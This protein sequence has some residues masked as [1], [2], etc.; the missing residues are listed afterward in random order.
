MRDDCGASGRGC[1]HRN[2]F[3]GVGSW[4]GN[5]APT[6]VRRS[7]APVGDERRREFAC[8]GLS[9]FGF[10]LRASGF[11]EIPPL[12]RCVDHP[13]PLVMNGGVRILERQAT[14]RPRTGVSQDGRWR[15]EP[16][17]SGLS[18]HLGFTVFGFWAGNPA[19]TSVRRSPAPAG[20]ER[21]RE[22]ACLG[23]S[24]FGF[25]LPPSS[26][27]DSDG[28]LNPAPTD[29]RCT[30]VGADLSAQYKMRPLLVM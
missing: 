27:C 20:D 14:P 9:A 2:G 21:R 3:T 25:L 29:C 18:V 10:R 12:R 17:A 28:M 13:H 6:T 23:L 15:V 1:Q 26:S 22:F 30:S 5:P 11:R 4:A 16:G 8:F 24:A 19:P 7:P